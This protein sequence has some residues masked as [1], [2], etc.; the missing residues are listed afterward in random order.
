MKITV[1]QDKNKV[2][3]RPKNNKTKNAARKHAKIVSEKT[4]SKKRQ[5]LKA[6]GALIKLLCIFA[7]KIIENIE[8]FEKYNRETRQ[9]YILWLV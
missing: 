4:R 7:R 3:N 1:K 5:R 8:L 2:Q 9:E 6:L